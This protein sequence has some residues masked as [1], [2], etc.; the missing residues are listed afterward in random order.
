G[1]NPDGS[2]VPDPGGEETDNPLDRNPNDPSDA[3]DD[4]TTVIFAP[5]PP[6]VPPADTDQPK[7]ELGD[8]GFDD[9]W[10]ALLAGVLMFA[11]AVAVVLRRRSS[12]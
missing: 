11:G 4:P 10:L 2:V 1:T 12:H 5:P 9:L 3:G 8:T 6:V 7:P